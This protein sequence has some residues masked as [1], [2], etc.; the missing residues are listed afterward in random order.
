MSMSPALCCPL[1]LDPFTSFHLHS[2][3]PPEELLL[4]LLLSI[5]F[6]NPLPPPVAVVVLAVATANAFGVRPSARRFPLR[7]FL[8]SSSLGACR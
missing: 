4:L 2:I 6:C 5:P 1:L 8:H 7:L 3:L